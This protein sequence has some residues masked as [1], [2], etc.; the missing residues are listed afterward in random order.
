M[1]IVFVGASEL[2]TWTVRLL[3]ERGHDVVIVER[4]RARIDDLSEEL[5][6]S[7]LHGDGSKPQVLAEAR[8]KE[9]DMLFCLTDNDQDNIIASLVGRSMGFRR[10]V[11]SIR[12]ADFEPICREL[13]LENIISPTRTISRYLADM[14]A[15]IDILEL[16]TIIK[17]EAR[18]FTFAAE[19]QHAGAVAELDLPK[20]AKVVCYYRNKEFFLADT[21]TELRKGDEVVILFHSENLKELRERF[22]PKKAEQ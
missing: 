1:R 8:P 20:K 21:E 5:D 11:T 4:D 6:C 17:G 13:S 22:E 14:V 10:V 19:K 12:D 3:I 16:S 2:T 7:F 18:F 9:T 15:G